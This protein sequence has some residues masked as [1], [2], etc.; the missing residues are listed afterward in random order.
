L[1]LGLGAPLR[2][3]RVFSFMYTYI[4][5][6]I[7]VEVSP[8]RFS[9]R[10]TLRA[11]LRKPAGEANFWEVD[12]PPLRIRRYVYVLT[13]KYMRIRIYRDICIRIYVYVFTSKYMR[14]RT[15]VYVSLFFFLFVFLFSYA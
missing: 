10:R 7:C 3:R 15:Y 9:P 13:S 6:R 5:I 14:I 1:R 12:F 2:I 8:Q 11:D 4:R